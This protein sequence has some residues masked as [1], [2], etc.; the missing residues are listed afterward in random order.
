MKFIGVV[1]G[2]SA[3]SVFAAPLFGYGLNK[4]KEFI[5]K[6]APVVSIVSEATGGPA[7]EGTDATAAINGVTPAISTFEDASKPLAAV[8]N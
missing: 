3:S 2:L 1:I 7:F 6:S 8:S 5:D 4:L